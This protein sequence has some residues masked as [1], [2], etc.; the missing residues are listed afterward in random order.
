[1]LVRTIRELVANRRISTEELLAQL[2]VRGFRRLEPTDLF[3]LC[4][5]HRIAEFDKTTEHWYDP[6]RPETMAA[7]GTADRAHDAVADKMAKTS[8][9]FRHE[10]H[11]LRERL[12]R[13]F[14]APVT[15]ASPVAPGWKD[16]ATAARSALIRE[17]SAVVSKTGWQNIELIDGEILEE[18]PTRR[19]VRY[20]IQGSDNVREGTVAS[21][22]PPTGAATDHRGGVDVEVLTQYGSEITV[23]MRANEPFWKQA[24]LKCDLSYLVTEQIGKFSELIQGPTQ[25][26]DSAAALQPVST[27]GVLERVPPIEPYPVAGLNERQRLAVAHGLCSRL[28]WL[29][30]PP[31]TGK[32]TTLAVLLAELLDAGKTVL[33]AAPTNAAIDV[34]L[35]ALLRRRPQFSTGEVVRIGPTVDDFLTDRRPAV[36]LDEIAADQ[37][38][39]PARRLVE[40]RR[41][42]AELRAR[43]R[44]IPAREA[45]RAQERV[46]L[47]RKIADLGGF[48]KGLV[49]LLGEVRDQVIQEAQLIACTAHQVVLKEPVRDKDFDV[50]VID[51]ASMMTAAM[52]MLVAGTGV[53][54][55]IV[56]GDFRQ[57][58][59]IVQSNDPEAREWLSQSAFEK[60]G[61][62]KAVGSARPPAN[63][64]ALDTQHRMRPEIGDAIGR[65]FYTEVGL[66]T[67][68]SVRSRPARTIPQGEP[69]MILIDTAELRAP[70]ARREGMSSRYNVM[71]AQLAANVLAGLLRAA[72]APGSI[73]LISPFAP[74]AKLMQALAPENDPRVLASTVH[75]FQGGE[76][77]VVLYDAVESSGSGLDLHDW[78]KRTSAGSE[79]ARLLNVAMSRA[80]EQAIMLADMGRIHR[81]RAALRTP[82]R[83][84]LQNLSQE[85]RQWTW[86][87][88]AHGS[89]PTRIEHS[90]ALLCD[91]IAHAAD[92]VQIFSATVDGPVTPSILDV[93]TNLPDRVKIEFWFGPSS[94]GSLVER[95]LRDHHT[96]LHPLQQCRESFVVTDSV[97]W[98]AQAPI[99]GRD[100][101]VLLRSE[102]PDLAQAVRRQSL[103]RHINGVPGTGDDPERCACGT[104]RMRAEINGGPRAGI[105]SVC[106]RCGE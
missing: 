55:T 98:S 15:A 106:P 48:A 3:M 12:V 32:T 43:H 73:G 82:V 85:A 79:G 13:A 51:E 66:R 99:L 46:A 59:P 33:L 88:V 24:R 42:L 6:G 57:L 45:N 21:L 67:A 35:S 47:V 102:H 54:H 25:G 23:D 94:I 20:E 90:L 17:K 75:R 104:L 74:Q 10:L 62:A 93:L 80:R 87:E 22:L 65:S 97:L 76:T 77:D 64:V 105:R 63:L 39:E 83:E 34:A 36:L 68:A 56:A 72:A 30:G 52:T 58:P 28:T 84:F 95:A 37:G 89:G 44:A 14:E 8:A 11:V 69:E 49:A 29:W 103:R 50:V 91:D 27:A 38:A 40:I 4:H 1:M 78:F 18:T 70:L 7:S 26:F 71:H 61:V 19:I 101:G 5:E 16:M 96:T 53:G 92:S 100:P 9:A 86:R 60:S 2:D 41:E 81:S 31:G